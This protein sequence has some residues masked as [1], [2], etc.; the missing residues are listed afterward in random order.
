MSRVDDNE[1]FTILINEGNPKF[2][3]LKSENSPFLL[4]LHISEL[5]IREIT[6]YKNPLA[7]PSDLDESIS[8][9]YNDKYFQ[10]KNK[11]G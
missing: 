3:R 9:F 5:L 8:N 2:L 4:A 11:S 10:V 6:V 7:S 1:N